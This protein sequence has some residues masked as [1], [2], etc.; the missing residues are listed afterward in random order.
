MRVT[1]TEEPYSDFVEQWTERGRWPAR[2]IRHPSEHGENPKIAAFRCKFLLSEDAVIRIHVTADER[3]NLFL[4]G[5]RIGR[6]P[7]R[8]D[9][10][11]WFYETYDINLHVG[12]HA[13]VARVW[14]LG[15]RTPA[16]YA[17]MS[18]THGFLLAAE[19]MPDN[20]LNTGFA[21]WDCK[22]LEG[23]SFL[24][25]E[26]AWGTGAKV[27]IRGAEFPWGFEKGEGDGW[28]E[29]EVVG[30]AANASSAN[31]FP[32]IWMLRPAILP[33]M[34]EEPINAG[35]ARFVQE[36]HVP[37][38]RPLPVNQ[39]ECLT[40]EMEEWN[41]LLAGEGPVTI[42]PNI[43]R[44]VII[45]L[46]N[47]F[48][49]Y[50]EI[51][52]SGGKGS[53]I[54]IFWAEA[55]YESEQ[56]GSK[57]NRD[58][59]EGKYFLG[60]G[61]IFEP[62]GGGHRRFETLWWEAGRYLEVLVST[63]D[64]PLSIEDFHIRE[65]HYPY[66]YEGDFESDDSSLDYVKR[67]GIRTLEMCSHETYMDCPYYE[68]LQYVGDTRLEVLTTYCLTRDDSLPRKAML[69]FDVSRKNSGITQSRYP[70]RVMQIIPPFSLLWIAMIHDYAMWRDD[71]EF[72]AERMPGVR[73]VLDVFRRCI[74]A[75]GL[76]EAPKGWNF[77]DWVLAWS[78]GIPPDGDRGVSGIINWQAA[79]VFRQAAELEDL[80]GE[81]ELAARN[82]RV[83][84]KIS[85]VAV[86]AF[87]HEGRGLLADDL[88]KK[89]FSEHSQCLALLNGELQGT[90]CDRVIHG[91]LDDPSLE[92]TTI[93]F[94]HYLFEAY[95]L[96]G[97]M[98]RFF[99]RM[100]LWFDLEEQG[101]K[102]TL[103]M[104]EPSRSDCHAW[105][106][107]PIYHYF[108]SIL[109]IRPAAPG[110]AKVRIEPQLAH[111]T[112]AK[113]TLPHPRGFIKVDLSVRLN[114]LGG[115][116][117]LPEGVMGTMVVGN[118]IRYLNPGVQTI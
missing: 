16:P 98:D 51:T 10:E 92:R 38:T 99:Q 113:C 81:P 18:V 78:W 25:P 48:T 66:K 54:R 52:V 58:E 84:D 1:I 14:W 68:Q 2:W 109:G 53:T 100:G 105:G 32:P 61:D 60:I 35:Q 95:K 67:I 20:L 30:P 86:T 41:R 112:K 103:E 47:Y 91:L 87:W 117:E 43:M 72:V 111:L 76:V 69:M 101:F 13:L 15:S 44:R 21:P 28:A 6:G 97:R 29:P 3:Y 80:V 9:R 55:L 77:M 71:P 36:V 90:K 7:E 12:E 23:Y 83:A 74:N 33:P 82:R 49:A 57:G 46:G 65:T 17:Q 89:H 64:E 118:Q 62:D 31:E 108:A 27:R 116:V 96:L 93:Y 40:S 26:W 63:K 34:L 115:S 59:I 104:P 70:S 110:F 75:D 24:S 19:G 73:S 22:V 4:D 56:G 88:G 39:S 85:R 45:D 5:E 94:N 79:M 107:H 106:A 114:W 11:N 42:G 102:T 8:G 37:D 50:P